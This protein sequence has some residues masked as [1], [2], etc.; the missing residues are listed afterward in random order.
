[1]SDQFN[2]DVFLSHSSKDKAVV[3]EL[4]ER[5]RKDGL[6]VW[7][8]EWV[9]KPGDSIP[10]KI[11]E[12]LEHSR[13]L[14]LCMSA[15]AFGSD[16]A[17]LE[18]GTFRFRDP[19]NKERRFIPL[20]LDDAPIK[21]SL[22]Q[23][24][25]INWLPPNREPEYAKLLDACRHPVNWPPPDDAVVGGEP[26]GELEIEGVQLDIV[27][28]SKHLCQVRIH[29]ESSA[30]TADNV[31]VELAEFEDALESD[32]QA[33]YFRPVLPFALQ[34]ARPG[35]NTIN[36]GGSAKYD[37]FH[38]TKNIKTA[39]RARDGAVTGW[40]QMVIAYFTHE[41]TTNLTQFACNTLYRLRFIVTARDLRKVKQDFQLLFSEQGELCRFSLTP[42]LSRSTRET[43][44][45]KR[46]SLVEAL[47]RF[48][49]ALR[50]RAAEVGKMASDQYHKEQIDGTDQTTSKLLAE[51]EAYFKKN[52]A[53][54]GMASLAD[55]TSNE[56]MDRSPIHCIYGNTIYHDEWEQ[57]QRW[58]LQLEKNL[59]GITDK[60][61]SKPL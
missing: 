2:F 50:T 32:P 33:E 3:R 17:Q 34:P 46:T 21:G 29:N 11:E 43:A 28:H 42:A 31:Q 13:V 60:L 48:R 12:G 55:L 45:Q 30:R 38:V 35:E 9:L 19:L 44:I 6:K 15:N 52:P 41:T 14:V 37:L 1:M 36:P 25:Y 54:L 22:A 40:Q 39:T 8:D 57:M 10:A 53:D 20:R 4:A 58:L 16:W 26:V 49:F 56:G 51:I 24:L 61:N 47:A 59:A 23:F 7:F 18:A 27:S 5:L